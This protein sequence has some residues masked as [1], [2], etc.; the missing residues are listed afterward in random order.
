MLDI[1]AVLQ[2]YCEIE[3]KLSCGEEGL[4]FKHEYADVNNVRLHYVAEGKGK[5]DRKSVV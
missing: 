1:S 2:V 4:M 3:K 5:L